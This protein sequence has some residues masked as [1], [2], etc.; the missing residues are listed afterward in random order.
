MIYSSLRNLSSKT[1]EFEYKD[2]YYTERDRAGD[3]GECPHCS[4]RARNRERFFDPYKDKEMFIGCKK[5]GEQNYVYCFECPKCFNKFYYHQMVS[6]ERC[7][8]DDFD[9]RFKNKCK[10]K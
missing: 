9:K 3:Q 10:N 2:H 4:Y 8:P 5:F 6:A 7:F 1:Y